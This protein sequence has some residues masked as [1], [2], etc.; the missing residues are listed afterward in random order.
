MFAYYLAN[1][2]H[3]LG[4]EVHVLVGRQ[5]ETLDTPQKEGLYVYQ[6]VIKEGGNIPISSIAL[7]KAMKICRNENPD[8]IYGNHFEETLVGSCVKH[9]FEI[10]LISVLHKTPLRNFPQNI[11][12]RRPYYCFFNFVTELNVDRFV[13]GSKAFLKEL[14]A[15]GVP[16]NKSELIYHG[17]PTDEIYG[18][19]RNAR[20][21]P[22]FKKKKLILCPARLDE[23][24]RL[25]IF[26]KAC[27]EVK[28]KVDDDLIF[29][30]TGEGETESDKTYRE[31]LEFLAEKRGISLEDELIFR[32]FSLD[33][34]PSLYKSAD[35]MVLPSDREGLG[36]VLLEG[37]AF[38]IPVVASNVKGPKE[39]IED[40][41]EGLLFDSN[42]FSDLASQ[43]VRV[44]N[45]QK[46]RRKLKTNARRKV[47]QDFSDRRMA[48]NYIELHDR[49]VC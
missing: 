20:F 35:V 42:D 48:E 24:K 45:N 19:M 11:V 22:E 13:A 26:V 41:E 5:G 23:R 46:L 44:L 25:D 3:K 27:S 1:A 15:M 30:I 9:S 43:L 18:K 7:D 36:L 17:I 12:K 10:P 34:T 8:L 31:E 40:E 2:L 28:Q 14:R 16:K 29:L 4:T 38:Q 32:S 33:K 49:I 37:M 21:L 6:K 47:S 39:V